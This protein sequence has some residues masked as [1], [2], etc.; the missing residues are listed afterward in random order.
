MKSVKEHLL[1]RH[2][3][4]N[5]HNPVIDEDNQ[6]AIFYLWNTSGQLVGYQQYRPTASK[7]QHNHPKEGRY[8]TFRPKDVV[9][10]WGTESL[11][12]TPWALFVTEGIFDAC[13]LTEKGVSAIAV[14]S[15][16][17][18]HTVRTWINSLSRRIIAVCD[19][20]AAG[21]KLAKLG[22]DVVVVP[23]GDLG[24]APESYIDSLIES[25]VDR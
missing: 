8:Y 1:Y 15:N 18:H 11:H 20:D 17:P 4:I 24:D 14:L 10:V 6:L 3:D 12:L 22:N 25:Y 13:R 9:A 2:M 5:F 7:E 21:K 16:D 19:N 23:N